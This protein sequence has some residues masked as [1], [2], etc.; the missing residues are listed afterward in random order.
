[1]AKSL[2]SP[3]SIGFL[4]AGGGAD[5]GDLIAS[6]RRAG[7]L[8]RVSKESLEL[9]RVQSDQNIIEIATTAADQVR[10]QCPVESEE[11]AL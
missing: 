9:A 3:Y 6:E 7:D 1:L 11:V 5:H 8:C 4:N 2:P 10:T